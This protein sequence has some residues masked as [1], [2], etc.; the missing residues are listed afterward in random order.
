MKM[1]LN[2]K[3]LAGLALVG[4]GI[5]VVAPGFVGA[6]LPVLIL[7]ACPLS[8]VFMAWGMRGGQCATQPTQAGQGR[9]PALTAGSREQQLEALRV[10]LSSIQDQQ[11]AIAREI[12]Q[13]EAPSRVSG[14]GSRVPT[15]P[16][17]V[18]RKT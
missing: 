10:Q 13:L 6:A 12:A 1:C 3:V 4:V 14:L 16:Q 7:L 2:W 8:M 11:R 18:R 5:W 17:D 9:Q 15:S